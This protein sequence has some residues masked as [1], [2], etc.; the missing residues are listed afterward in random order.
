VAA[1]PAVAA[2][3]P[4]RYLMSHLA[5]AEE[6]AHPDNR[7]QRAAFEAVRAHFPGVAAS[8]ANSSGIF[9]GA[10]YHYALARPG[11][12]LYGVAPVSGQPNPQRPVIRLRARVIQTRTVPAG[13]GV[14]YGH[15]W[16]APG[17][18]RLATL[19]IGYADGYLRSLSNRGVVWHAGQE[20]PIVGN[21]SMDTV[22]VDVSR[23][24]EGGLMPGDAVDVID[25]CQ[26]VDAVAG[27]AGTI[28]YEI[29]TSLGQ[30][31]ARSYTGVSPLRRRLDR[32]GE[33]P[34]PAGAGALPAQPGVTA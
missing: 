10:D 27:R 16:R 13:T 34:C 8:L 2:A 22:V 15:T 20:L 23:L 18:A 1:D 32:I 29:L 30:R 26:P 5:C 17:P 19:A 24:P 28:A 12:A 3:I 31:Y 25:P 21:V 6:S 9:L 4:W 11:A 7:A 33:R 14:G